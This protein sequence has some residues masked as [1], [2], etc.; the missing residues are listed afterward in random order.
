MIFCLLNKKKRLE[1]NYAFSPKMNSLIQDVL[2]K[3]M[4]L[5]GAKL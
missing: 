4:E 2:A 3:N 1:N 5:V